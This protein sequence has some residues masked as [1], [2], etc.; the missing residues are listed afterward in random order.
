MIESSS[1]FTSGNAVSHVDSISLVHS[2][3]K[4]FFDIYKIDRQGRFRALKCVKKQLRGQPL[5]EDMLRK[6]FE[7][8]WSLRHP[9][10]VEYYGYSY[11]E[12][13]GNCIEMEWVDGYTLEEYEL[14]GPVPRK[15]EDSMLDELCDALSYMHK[16]GVLHRDLKPSNI[17][18]THIGNN[19][20]LIDFGLSDSSCHSSL[21]SPAGT[22]SYA[23]PE[24][25]AGDEA[26]IRSEIYSLGLVIN[27]ISGRHARV[28][29]RCCE[30]RPSRRYSSVD[31]VKKELHGRSMLW[32]GYIFIPIVVVAAIFSLLPREEMPS[33]DAQTVVIDSLANGIGKAGISGQGDDVAGQGGDAAGQDEGKAVIADPDRQSSGKEISVRKT[34]KNDKE[35]VKVDTSMIDNLFRQATDLFY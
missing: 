33:P 2:S 23:A 8:G 35:E 4:G 7:I 29:R 18:V 1:L 26:D 12:D 21:K 34:V 32:A 11:Y 16:K 6:E 14:K 30:R 20:R 9:N 15:Q 22:K 27:S 10:I 3:D 28:V 17:L 5:Y 24:V 25:L 13:L 31:E 19:I